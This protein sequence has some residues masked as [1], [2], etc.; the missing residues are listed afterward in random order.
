MP[1]AVVSLRLDAGLVSELHKLAGDCRTS[2][3]K[4]AEKILLQFFQLDRITQNA[5]LGRKEAS[6]A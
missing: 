3:S 2:R 1:K 5:T 6:H 4:L